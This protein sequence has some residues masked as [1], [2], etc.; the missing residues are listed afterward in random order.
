MWRALSSHAKTLAASAHAD[1]RYGDLPYLHHLCAVVAVLER[2]GASLDDPWT[3]PILVAA[4]LHDALEDTPLP[5]DTLR[6]QLN[7]PIADLVWLVTDEP[8]PNRKARKAATYLKL[9]RSEPAIT[10]KLADRIANVEHCL[11]SNPRL[12]SMYR[13]EHPSF[14]LALAPPCAHPIPLA[15]WSHLHGLLGG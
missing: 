1:Q 13:K 15:M 7:D 10:L 14:T 6:Q 12:L 9:Q 3:A 11:L 5:L 2:F 4:W 8:G